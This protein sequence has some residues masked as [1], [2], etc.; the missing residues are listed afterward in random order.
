MWEQPGQPTTQGLSTTRCAR[1]TSKEVERCTK[2]APGSKWE[3]KNLFEV[4]RTARVAAVATGRLSEDEAMRVQ[5]E[6]KEKTA[7][8]AGCSR[9]YSNQ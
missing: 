5:E 7:S 8:E 6:A 9:G 4:H 1:Y 2:G 3:T